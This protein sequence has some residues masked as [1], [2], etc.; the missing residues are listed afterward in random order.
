MAEVA[1]FM[2]FVAALMVGLGVVVFMLV[3]RWDAIV[4]ALAQ[5]PIPSHHRVTFRKVATMRPRR[6]TYQPGPTRQQILRAAA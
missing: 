4:A 6:R 1:I 2:L 3:D 5:E